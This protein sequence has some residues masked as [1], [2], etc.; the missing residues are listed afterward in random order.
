MRG[1][2]GLPRRSRRDDGSRTPAAPLAALGGCASIA[3]ERPVV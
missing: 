1:L 3:T 2:L